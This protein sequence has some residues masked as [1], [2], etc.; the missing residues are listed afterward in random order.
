M[1]AVRCRS[2]IAKGKAVVGP[3]V[4]RYAKA[5][6][7]S[8]H[9]LKRIAET[10]LFRCWNAACVTASGAIASTALARAGSST[11]V[12]VANGQSGWSVGPAPLVLRTLPSTRGPICMSVLPTFIL[13]GAVPSARERQSL[14]CASGG[15]SADGC[16]MPT[17]A[18]A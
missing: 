13:I 12:F 16:A 11:G 7:L 17:S 1:Q 5:R 14:S 15:A 4:P 10:H 18:Y 9:A 3:T 6:T 2:P 8:K